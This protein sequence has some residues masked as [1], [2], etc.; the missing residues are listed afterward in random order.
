MLDRKTK[1]IDAR[2]ELLLDRIKMNDLFEN[3]YLI[4]WTFCSFIALGFY[5]TQ[6]YFTA[7]FFLVVG[8]S[9]IVMCVY[10]NVKMRFQSLLI[11]L[12]RNIE[13][14]KEK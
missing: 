2:E 10:M 9:C 8:I 6:Y 12:K 14:T 4:L 3:I 5:L 7:I 13:K 11:Y 1:N